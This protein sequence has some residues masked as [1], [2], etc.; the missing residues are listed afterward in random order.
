MPYD[1]ELPDPVRFAL[2]RSHSGGRLCMVF[3]ILR[4]FCNICSR[5]RS[6]CAVCVTGTITTDSIIAI[7]VM[8]SN[9]NIIAFSTPIAFQG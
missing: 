7:A 5:L 2:L 6:A 8:E 9:F 1:V 4:P 3:T